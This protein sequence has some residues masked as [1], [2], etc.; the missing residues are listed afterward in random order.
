MNTLLSFCRI[1][2]QLPNL[3][4]CAINKESLYNAFENGITSEQANIL[5]WFFFFLWSYYLMTWTAE[6]HC[7]TWLEDETLQYAIFEATLLPLW[8]QSNPQSLW[9]CYITQIKVKAFWM[10]CSIFKVTMELGFLRVFEMDGS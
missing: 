9:I 4:V 1:E 7:F 10:L 2:Y 5:S 8:V 6:P 3:I